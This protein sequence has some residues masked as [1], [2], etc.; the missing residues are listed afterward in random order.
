MSSPQ[1]CAPDRTIY[2][3]PSAEPHRSI[4]PADHPGGGCAGPPYRCVAG[5]RH[6]TRFNSEDMITFRRRLRADEE[7]LGNVDTCKDPGSAPPV[8]RAVRHAPLPRRSSALSAGD[9]L[10]GMYPLLLCLCL[11]PFICCPSWQ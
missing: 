8:L 3:S 2:T 9:R 11:P 1:G 4:P 10:L 5:D 7:Q 6:S